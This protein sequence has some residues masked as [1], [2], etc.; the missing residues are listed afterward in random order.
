MGGR[1][2]VALVIIL[3]FVVLLTG[4]VIAFFSRSILDRQISNSHAS[5]A[6]VSD[7]ANGAASAIIG[8]LKQE[9]VLS[10]SAY[11]LSPSSSG[12]LYA[13]LPSSVTPLTMLPAPSGVATAGTAAP[14]LLISSSGGQTFYSGTNGA[15]QAVSVPENSTA[16]SSTTPS[17]NGRYITPA[18]WNEH[19]LLPINSSADSTPGWPGA[20]T[21]T[22]PSWVL[23]ARDG[24]NPTQWNSNMIT[25]GSNTSSVIGRYAFAIYHEGGLLDVNAAGYP[26]STGTFSA[27]KDGTPYADLSQVFSAAGIPAATATN[28]IDQL[29]AWRNYASIPSPGPFSSPGFV[30]SSTTAIATASAYSNYVVSNTTGYLGIS[31]TALNQGQTDRMFSSRQELIKFAQNVWG[32]SPNSTSNLNFKV[33]NYLATF[34][35]DLNAPSYIPVQSVDSASPGYVA[36]APHILLPSQ[37]GNN[38][39][40]DTTV[41]SGGAWSSPLDNQINCAFPAVRVPVTTPGGRND[42]TDLVQGEPLV[43][44]RFVLNRLA[45]LTYLGPSSANMTDPTVQQTITSLGGNPANQNDPVYKFVAQGT[46]PNIKNYFGLVWS[47]SNWSYASHNG[48]NTGTGGI[49]KV[50]R[51]LSVTSPDASNY[52]QDSGREPDFFELLKATINAGSIAK[53]STLPPSSSYQ[54]STFAT[55]YE[56]DSRVDDAIIQIGANI[57][58]QFKA[59]NYPIQIT[60]DDGSGPKTFSGIEDLPYLYR[61]HPAVLKVIAPSVSGT[62]TGTAL[63]APSSV[64][65]TSTGA[66]VT[67]T[68]LGATLLI[69]ELWDPHDWVSPNLTA[70]LPVTVT[71]TGPT[72]FRIYV[73]QDAPYTSTPVTVC[74]ANDYSNSSATGSPAATTTALGS[75]TPGVSDGYYTRGFSW[76]GD[77]VP[78]LSSASQTM[79]FQIPYSPGGSQFFREPTLLFKPGFPAGANL[80]APALASPSAAELGNLANVTATGT[81]IFQGGGLV[82]A[83]GDTGLAAAPGPPVQG[84][85]YVGFYIGTIPLVWRNTDTTPPTLPLFRS[86]YV[87][88]SKTAY[89]NGLPLGFY[90]QYEYPTGSKNWITYDEKHLTLGHPSMTYTYGEIA[91]P[92]HHSWAGFIQPCMQGDR[93]YFVFDPR[94]SRFGFQTST[95]YAQKA[96]DQ[97]SSD[98][99]TWSFPP[100]SEIFPGGGGPDGSA[101]PGT[102]GYI[103]PYLPWISRTQGIVPSLRDGWGIGTNMMATL[104]SVTPYNFPTQ[105]GFYPGNN[106]T[107]SS[108]WTADDSGSSLRIGLFSENTPFT[109]WSDRLA[110]DAEQ[111]G[112]ASI[113]PD[114]Y[115][116][117]LPQFY[118]DADGVV[119]R[120]MGGWSDN[121]T[122]DRT[123]SNNSAWA[124]AHWAE[125]MGLPM[126]VAHYVYP[127]TTGT[128]LQKIDIL[129]NVPASVPSTASPLY[130]AESRSMILHRPFRTVAEMGYAFS[131]TPWKDLDFTTPESG[132]AALLDVFCISDTADANGVTEGRVNL[133]TR[134]QPVIQAIIAGAYKDALTPGATASTTILSS[135]LAARLVARTTGVV[136]AGVT[137]SGSGVRPLQ[138]IADLVGRWSSPM[139]AAISPA[140]T[141][142]PPY[143]STSYDGFSADLFNPPYF[144][145]ANSASYTTPN[146]DPSD[147][148]PALSDSNA[149]VYDKTVERRRDAPIRALANAG[150]T[151]VWNLLIDLVAQTGR[152]PQA[153]A[154]T[155]NPLAAFLVEGETHYWVHVAID[156][157]TGQVIDKQVEVVRE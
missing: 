73:A 37:G 23:V 48:G 61:V 17:L 147:T 40:G 105:M 25:S 78:A 134:Q 152:Y 65:T 30:S 59:D 46:V 43:K 111:I 85:S 12:T 135:T 113:N 45:W 67:D 98:W 124:N 127:I 44:K 94:T 133:N 88:L 58:D 1:G 103:A 86:E 122:G 20:G 26:S 41:A 81:R 63:Y 56:N 121:P 31:G 62:P 143:G 95:V 154:S 66:S 126:R 15:G 141:T 19:Y 89:T 125:L 151:R 102:V 16:V 7:L 104:G 137:V 91:A 52:V 50:G 109:M 90:L 18:R 114:D 140:A 129:K 97:S 22:P 123:G 53:A 39:G 55:Q 110:G 9:I 32:F 64:V 150:Q 5:Q 101:I 130:Q 83:V 93:H 79:T 100:F 47:G 51:P 96:D 145:N 3:A 8:D 99:Y 38:A 27:Y 146:T 156:R 80:A 155:S 71:G 82:A 128:F 33:L 138:N 13:P 77:Q 148:D 115:G 153:S 157:L 21:F 131:G 28:C 2:G 24:S 49:M 119:R 72:S 87:T 149:I 117:A 74:A 34:T 112:A 106:G 29:V 70:T 42:G 75:T 35:R 36:G 76:N 116:Q 132:N 139:S 54:I 144:L 107:N 120:A 11:P 68:G 14:N 69:P 142:A 108:P 10:S 92:M 4:L 136:P 57:V 60:F 84:T 118:E 6:K